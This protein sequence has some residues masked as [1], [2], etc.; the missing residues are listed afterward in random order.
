MT[1]D[2]TNNDESFTAEYP[3]IFF[4]TTVGIS[5]D[6]VL[7]DLVNYAN[8]LVEGCQL[9]SIRIATVTDIVDI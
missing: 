6:H 7:A 9:G 1:I 2:N 8:T 3:E 5:L 4:P